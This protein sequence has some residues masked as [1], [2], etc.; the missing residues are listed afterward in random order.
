M[1]VKLSA[2]HGVLDRRLLAL[3]LCL[4][5]TVLLLV[6][7]CG[8]EDPVLAREK[9]MVN[10]GIPILRSGTSVQRDSVIRALND[11]ENPQ[12]LHPYIHDADPGVQISVISALGNLKD[13]NA[14]DS[15][16]QLLLSSED[17][18]LRETVIW[19]LGELSDTSS[20]P[21]LIG[22][23]R[24]T[25]QNRDLRLG[26]PITLASFI[27]TAYASKVEQV[28]VDLLQQQS[29]DLE[30]CSYAAVGMLEILRPGNYELF[31][32][33]LPLLKEL[34]AKRLEESG[35][36]GIYMNFQLTVEALENYDPGAV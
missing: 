1:R 32:E 24:D 2:L 14:V 15:L 13:S 23:L 5:A 29:D 19:A 36:D 33:Q 16:N 9:V 7:G 18:L 6:C 8:K 34:T 20:V 35:E 4:A 31:K 22:I 17:Y 21:V 26:L 11:L 27:N 10:E 25:T 30:L 28:F 3:P 12:L